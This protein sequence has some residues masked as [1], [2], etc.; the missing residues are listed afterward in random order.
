MGLPEIGSE[1][2][3]RLFSSRVLVVGAG[4]LGSPILYYL[5]AAGVGTIGILDPDEVS[6][7]N[8]NRQILHWSEDIGRPK[9][10]SAREKL[11]RFNPGL[12][13]NAHRT[14]LDGGNAEKIV[15]DYDVVMSAVDSIGSRL[16]INEACYRANVPW[17]DGGVDRF[18]GL[19]SVYSPP[20]GPCY[21]CLTRGEE[22]KSGSTPLLLG[23]LAGTIALLQT[24]EALK[25][26]LKIG[27]P[28]RGRILF[29]DALEPRFDIVDFDPDPECPVCGAR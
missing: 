10:D 17:I 25:L 15:A 27:T 18:A 9:T 7:S 26:I 6:L 24:Q 11:I 22:H 1:G 29:Y 12:T 2:Q 13:V 23:A 5:A 19:V 3:E 8:L 14:A 21:R 20:K 28:L 4:G 16:V